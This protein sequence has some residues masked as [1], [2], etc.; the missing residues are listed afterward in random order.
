MKVTIKLEFD[1][2]NASVAAVLI[3]AEHH[4]R[5]IAGDIE[6]SQPVTRKLKL[7]EGTVTGQIV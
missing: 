4:V 1:T 3:E 7:A 2:R 5:S 6:G